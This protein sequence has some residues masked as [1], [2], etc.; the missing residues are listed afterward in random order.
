MFSPADLV[1]MWIT[2]AAVMS[3]ATPTATMMNLHQHQPGKKIKN[4]L[5]YFKYSFL[6]F[7]QQ[8]PP[9]QSNGRFWLCLDKIYVA[10]DL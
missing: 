8:K 6:F 10:V 3:V 4:T 7:S 2:T 5:K 9:Q 1:Q